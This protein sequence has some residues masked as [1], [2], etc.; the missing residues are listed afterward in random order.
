MDW[1]NTL[2]ELLDRELEQRSHVQ[3]LDGKTLEWL[4]MLLHAKKSLVTIMAMEGS[5]N[6]GYS[7]RR[8]M[9][10][11]NPYGGDPYAGNAYR[12]SYDAGSYRMSRS[13]YSRSGNERQEM[14]ELLEE[15]LQKA[16]DQRTRQNIEN[17]LH[18]MRG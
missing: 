8:Y 14:T 4:D 18:N 3:Q 17:L 9:D 7:Q 16:P 11:Q 13:G 10:G 5:G 2:C 1:M 15:A 12:G 6:E